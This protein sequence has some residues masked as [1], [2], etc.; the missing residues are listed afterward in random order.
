MLIFETR[1]SQRFM[2]IKNIIQ[3]TTAWAASNTVNIDEQVKGYFGYS[4][5][6]NFISNMISFAIIIASIAFAAFL[7]MGGFQ[8][9]TSGGDKT[10]TEEAR[11]RITN[12]LIGL[13]IVTA[14]WAVWKIVV[15]FFGIDIDLA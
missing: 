4:N 15:Y 8:Y 13:V 9:L 12:A 5:L 14:S 11:S 10:K 3:P 7:I 2:T 1:I 6:G